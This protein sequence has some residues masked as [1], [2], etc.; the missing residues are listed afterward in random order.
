M[1]AIGGTIH[2]NESMEGTSKE[3]EG[4]GGMEEMQGVEGM[5]EMEGGIQTNAS[6]TL[7]EYLHQGNRLIAQL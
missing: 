1:S 5:E 4:I 3:M 7:D 2:S 6:L